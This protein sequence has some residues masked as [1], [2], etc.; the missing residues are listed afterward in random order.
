MELVERICQDPTIQALA[1]YIGEPRK[2]PQGG[3]ACAKGVWGSSAPLVSAALA[4]I[5]KRP[6]L[7]VSAHLD[8]ADNAQDDL[9]VFTGGEI[10]NEFL[11]S[12]G[13]LPGAHRES[14]PVYPIVLGKRPPW[15]R[16]S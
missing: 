10:V 16:D 6:V 12:T 13:Y 7:L 1:R 9:E 15:S 5:L 14:C 4:H 8:N 11:V 3:W 2:S